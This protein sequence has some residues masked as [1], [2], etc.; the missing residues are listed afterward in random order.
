MEKV[1]DDRAGSGM[2]MDL[3]VIAQLRGDKETGLAI[4]RDSLKLHQTFRAGPGK[5]GL[6]LL[7]LAAASD[8]G[9]NTPLEFL[10]Q[11]SDISLAT[12]YFGPDVPLPAAI[13]A[14]DVAMVVA[15]ASADGAHALTMIENLTRSWTTP[16]LNLPAPIRA[17]ERDQL[18]RKLEGIRGLRHSADRAA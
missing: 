9:A 14:H 10:V 7:A 8:I 18:C 17:L 15:P 16:V 5:P 11:G 3:S 4:Q 6:R 13:P 2:G 1:T 12:L